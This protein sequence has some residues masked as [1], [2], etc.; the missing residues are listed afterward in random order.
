MSIIHRIRSWLPALWVAE[1][2]DDATAEL[3]GL[4]LLNPNDAKAFWNRA[5]AKVANGDFDGA[6][7]DYSKSIRLHWEQDFLKQIN[8]K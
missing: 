5:D 6:L 7:S 3:D 4:I 1:N 8:K 2:E